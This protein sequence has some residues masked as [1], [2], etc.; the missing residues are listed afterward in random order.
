MGVKNAMK[1]QAIR[2]VAF[3]VLLIGALAAIRAA[4]PRGAHT[5]HH[6]RRMNTRIA[7]VAVLVVLA[8]YS[9]RIDAAGAQEPI[10]L[11]AEGPSNVCAGEDFA[12]TFRFKVDT[13]QVNGLGSFD[14][15]QPKNTT[16]VSL[17]PLGG[18]T[19]HVGHS[20]SDPTVADTH[21]F[22]STTST[23]GA[24]RLV[25]RTAPDFT[26]QVEAM[27]F[28]RG[29]GTASSNRVTTTI[30]GCP[31]LLPGT[32]LRSDGDSSR[33]WLVLAVLLFLHGLIATSAASALHLGRESKRR[34]EATRHPAI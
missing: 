12:I 8:A 26:G 28:I 31:A 32:G 24:V 3:A 34:R 10:I 16:Y 2:L 17:E 20:N 23:E 15:P 19:G 22:S 1:P 18:A 27:A 13:T 11:T 5:A 29:T 33:P 25:L 7:I 9:V 21:T 6:I 14:I 30:A 4:V